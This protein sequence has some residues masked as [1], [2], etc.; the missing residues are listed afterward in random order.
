[1]KITET[2]AKNAR[3]QPAHESNLLCRLFGA[4]GSFTILAMLTL[5]D[6]VL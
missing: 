5:L 3:Q 2:R 1:M 4:K 6:S